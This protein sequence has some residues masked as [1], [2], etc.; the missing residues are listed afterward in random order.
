MS[1]NGIAPP[2]DRWGM[3]GRRV[4]VVYHGDVGVVVQWS[5]LGAGMC[6]AVIR[7]DDNTE[8]AVSSGSCRPLDGLGDLPS[9]RAVQE[10]VRL[11]TISQLQNIRAGLIADWR[12]PWPGA[13]HGKAI[14]GQAIAAALAELTNVR[15]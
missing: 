12:K 2:P 1:Q 5:P 7:R 4:R 9:R 14:V 15:K 13:E 8:V 6:D 3:V 10:Q 11:E